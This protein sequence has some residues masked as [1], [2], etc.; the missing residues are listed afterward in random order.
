MFWSLVVLAVL[1]NAAAFASLPTLWL[2][3]HAPLAYLKWLVLSPAATVM[4]I[5]T[6]LL[7]PF[8]AA[9]SVIAGVNVLPGYLSWFHTDDDDLDGGQHQLGWPSDVNIFRLWYQRMT[10]ICRN[11]AF[12][13][14]REWF[15]FH[16]DTIEEIHRTTIGQWDSN[17]K[18][19]LEFVVLQRQDG[20]K[21][22][23][24]RW[25]W[26]YANKTFFRTWIGWNHT[27]MTA[28][29]EVGRMKLKNAIHPMRTKP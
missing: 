2:F 10:W 3:R 11:P 18:S 12:G 29:S 16:Y 17:D 28:P 4:Y 15:G 1:L 22:F 24:L 7:S 23:S 14:D 21:V 13:F 8:L 20:A 19:S 6:Y 26:F 25:Q 27:R 9:Y 5:V